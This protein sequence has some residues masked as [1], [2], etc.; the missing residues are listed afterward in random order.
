M[1]DAADDLLPRN[2]EYRMQNQHTLDESIARKVLETVDAGLVTGLGKQVP[3]Q[4]CV[5][6]AVCYAYGL[7]HSDKPPCVGSAVR[8]FKIRLNDSRWSSDAARASGM[9][10]LAIAQLGSDALDQVAF[11]KAV[12]EGM[13]RRVVPIALRA[14]AEIADGPY[15]AA[16]TAAA[17]RCE[18]EGS[19][20]RY[21][22]AD[23][24]DAARY[25][26]ADVADVADVADAAR[27]AAAAAGAARYA[28]AAAA[29]GAAADAARHAADAARHAAD[30]ARH[31]ADAARY[32]ARDKVLIVAADVGLQAL[33]ALRSPGCAYL[34]LLEAE[35]K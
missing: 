4:M 3:G 17:E 29:A 18:R 33:I 22:A 14:A 31:A 28:D 20:A 13:I 19:A 34:H 32:A 35:G 1:L 6:A 23:V 9:R 26:A 8:E 10:A 2:E 27:Y 30:A 25:A 16:L 12:S 15:K 24:A 11:A 21:A 7:P 5:E